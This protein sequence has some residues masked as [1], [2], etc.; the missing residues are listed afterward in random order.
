[1]GT[2]IANVASPDDDK[3]ITTEGEAINGRAAVAIMVAL[4]G[5][6]FFTLVAASVILTVNWFTRRRRTA[7][8]PDS[9]R[10]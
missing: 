7:P 1:M 5:V 8:V 3:T 9:Q 4:A 10:P 6:V 2:P